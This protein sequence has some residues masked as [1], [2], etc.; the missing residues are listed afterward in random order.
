MT[1]L[2]DIADLRAPSLLVYFL[3]ATSM[4]SPGVILIAAF[5]PEWIVAFEF[6]KLALLSCA[7]SSPLVLLNWAVFFIFDNE[8]EKVNV[9]LPVLVSAAFTFGILVFAALAHVFFPVT[10]RGAIIGIT[11]VELVVFL[12]FMRKARFH[13]KQTISNAKG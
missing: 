5:R 4:L 11:I 6:S 10:V 2:R 7:L 12:H 9:V 3:L 13:A 1:L 8:I